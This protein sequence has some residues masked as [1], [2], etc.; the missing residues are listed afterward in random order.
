MT[1]SLEKKNFGFFHSLCGRRHTT[2]Q[3]NKYQTPSSHR[4]LHTFSHKVGPLCSSAIYITYT[5]DIENDTLTMIF[6]FPPPF[7]LL[8]FFTLPFLDDALG[9]RKVF[10]T[11]PCC[12]NASA[13][14]HMCCCCVVDGNYDASPVLQESF[15]G[16]YR[17]DEFL[18]EDVSAFLFML[19]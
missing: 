6:I 3:S 18:D 12:W 16:P 4:P 9:L 10:A 13:V 2:S 17:S 1:H 14:L 19:S 15:D 8:P 5:P 11:L 7:S